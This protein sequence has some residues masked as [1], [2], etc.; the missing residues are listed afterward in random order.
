MVQTQLSYTPCQMNASA[1]SSAGSCYPDEAYVELVRPLPLPAKDHTL[2]TQMPGR[3]KKDK[4]PA[5]G[6]AVCV[7]QRPY[8]DSSHV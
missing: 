4:E 2:M 6:H 8:T 3:C 1:S 5:P 7:K